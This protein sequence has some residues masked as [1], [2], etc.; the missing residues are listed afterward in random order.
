MILKKIRN[1]KNEF[2]FLFDYTKEFYFILFIT[3]LVIVFLAFIETTTVGSLI[4]AVDLITDQNK[5]NSYLE[6]LNQ[7]FDLGLNYKNFIKLFFIFVSLLFLLSAILQIISI[8]SSALIRE[9]LNFKLRN[10]IINSYL[11]K[12]KNEFFLGS[13]VGDLL[14]KLLVH[15]I[16]SASVV[17]ET[18]LILKNIII[19]CAIYIFLLI[20]S[21][22]T[23]IFLTI[24]FILI[25]LVFLAIG[26]NV[27]LKKTHLRNKYQSEIYS[28][29]NIIISAIKIIKIF[30]KEKYF[31]DKFLDQS[32]NYKEKETLIQTLFN[33][34]GV[35]IRLISILFLLIFLYVIL[36]YNNYSIHNLSFVIVYIGGAY[37]LVNLLQMLIIEHLL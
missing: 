31:S 29:S 13:K 35:L 32:L 37:K 34:P 6:I 7:K 1:Y 28:L 22:K 18:L 14:Q 21:V 30:N 9:K 23:T 20:I 10:L 27:L 5:F 12:K 19:S 33:L 11:T 2:K 17:W 8:Y 24:F 16:N 3:F 15:T 4:P 25:G 26:K 36:S